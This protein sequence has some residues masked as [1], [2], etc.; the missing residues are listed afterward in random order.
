MGCG[1]SNFA[2]SK[3]T[4]YSKYFMELMPILPRDSGRTGYL[5][6]CTIRTGVYIIDRL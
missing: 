5:A 1:I 2:L 3:A 6:L 4:K